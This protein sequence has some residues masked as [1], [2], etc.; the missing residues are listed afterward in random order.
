[1]RANAVAGTPD[2]VVARLREWQ[3][4]GASRFYLQVLDLED[5]DHL[6]LIAEEVLPH[7]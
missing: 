4:V 1:M 3:A 6:A 5:L 7:V 2:E